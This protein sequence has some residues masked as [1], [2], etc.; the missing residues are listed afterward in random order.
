VTYSRF[1]RDMMV[2]L[3][4]ESE[5][6]E[7]GMFPFKDLAEKYGLPIKVNWV[8]QLANEW[9]SGGYARIFK[10]IGD[11]TTWRAE[12]A[13]A[14]TRWVEEEFGDKD[15]VGQILAPVS[16]V[17][18]GQVD[19]APAADRIVR[20]SDN[21]PK[22]VSTQIALENLS[23]QLSGGND[24]G[25]LSVDEVEEAKREVWILSQLI[26]QEAVRISWVE[27]LAKN[28]L[29]WIA[30]KAAE[31]VLGALAIAALTAFAALIGFSL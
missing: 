16:Q 1:D 29:Q 3:Y 31:Q 12:I 11:P 2:A 9:E 20:F 23:Q 24:Y 30:A 4:Q 14:G 27:P 26:Q 8:I 6:S 10:H 22:L 21:A 5:A 25:E 13:A 28:C 19:V 15:G 7:G 17:V 18:D